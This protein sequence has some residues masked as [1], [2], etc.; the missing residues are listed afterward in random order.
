MEPVAKHLA[1]HASIVLLLGLLFGAP[2]AKAIKR[3]AEAHIVRSWQVAHVSLPLGATLMIATSAILSS[4]AVGTAT[5]W[6]LAIAL[7]VSSYSFCVALPLGALLG[8]RGLSS[9][10]PIGAKVVYA[11]NLLG[12]W[13]SL[14][15]AVILVYACFISL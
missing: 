6:A 3:G 10:G 4:L 15:A 11:G 7:I 1:F 8:H 9:S 13:A 5:K 2:Y 14:V 12:A